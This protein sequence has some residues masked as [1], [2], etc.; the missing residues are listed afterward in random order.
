M[1]SISLDSFIVKRIEEN[2][3]LF[4]RDELE[5]ISKNSKCINKIYLLGAINSLDCQGK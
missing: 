4:T 3:E 2:K 5:F 1:K